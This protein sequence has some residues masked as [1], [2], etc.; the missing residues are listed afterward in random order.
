MPGIEVRCHQPQT[1]HLYE[2]QGFNT[3]EVSS[4]ARYER[5]T[6]VAGNVL[7]VKDLTD[8]PAAVAGVE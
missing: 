2:R 8:T 3:V 7:M 1:G 6:G 4:D 5:L